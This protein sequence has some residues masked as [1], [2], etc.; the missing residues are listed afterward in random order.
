MGVV[1][2]SYS[3]MIDEK[4]YSFGFISEIEAKKL[5]KEKL[6]ELNIKY[7]DNIEYKWDGTI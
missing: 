2:S 5:A 7:N 3:M 4:K 6:K 1:G